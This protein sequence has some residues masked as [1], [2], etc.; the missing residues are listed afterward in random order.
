MQMTLIPTLI[1]ADKLILISENPL[2]QRYLRAIL[3]DCDCPAST[4]R[5]LTWRL[6]IR[7]NSF[8]PPDP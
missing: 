4:A 5:Q 3:T 8:R 6:F 1:L 2:N 7:T